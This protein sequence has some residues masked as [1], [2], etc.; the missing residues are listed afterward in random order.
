M[1]S[2]PQTSVCCRSEKQ[3]PPA[4]SPTWEKHSTLLKSFIPEPFFLSACPLMFQSLC[5]H[6]LHLFQ[7]TTSKI[8]FLPLLIFYSQA[9]LFGLATFVFY[10]NKHYNLFILKYLSTKITPLEFNYICFI[11]TQREHTW[12]SQLLLAM[13][14]YALLG[15]FFS[16]RYVLC[17]V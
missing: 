5:H 8:P 2:G 3:I 16:V 10:Q 7:P 6:W 17:V 1:L 13:G 9:A 14:R 4:H 15:A 12:R 11:G